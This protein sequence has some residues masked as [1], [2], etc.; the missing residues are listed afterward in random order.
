V[1]NVVEDWRLTRTTINVQECVKSRIN[2]K[3]CRK[4]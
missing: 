1:W 2:R 3:N 4:V